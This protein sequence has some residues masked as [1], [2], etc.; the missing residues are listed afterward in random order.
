DAANGY[1][2]STEPWAL[3]RDSAQAD[4]LGQ[5]LFDV[6]ESVRIVG[7]L[8]LPIMPRSAAEILRRMGETTPVGALRLEQARWRPDAER[9]LVKGDALWPR[10]EPAGG[11]APHTKTK[12]QRSRQ[13]DETKQT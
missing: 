9:V 1:I 5:V 3:A 13:V 2:A 11:A 7:I 4:R 12:S 8:L 10:V 6:A